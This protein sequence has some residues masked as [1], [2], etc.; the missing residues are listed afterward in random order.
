M[1]TN[2]KDIREDQL[3]E[4]RKLEIMKELYNFLTE[5]AKL[6]DKTRGKP[7]TLE[8]TGALVD[9]SVEAIE[10]I[11]SGVRPTKAIGQ[12]SSEDTPLLLVKIEVASRIARIAM[13][14]GTGKPD[15]G[16]VEEVDRLIEEIIE[17]ARR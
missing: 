17:V 3:K 12:K 5:S 11:F 7:P 14:G 4:L 9:G 1:K 6:T 8:E 15:D 16:N 10:E 13:I 2:L